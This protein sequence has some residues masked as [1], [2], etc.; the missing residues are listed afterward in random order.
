MDNLTFAVQ[1]F[2]SIIVLI[3][4]EYYSKEEKGEDKSSVDAEVVEYLSLSESAEE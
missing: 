2:C 1:N 4:C 3:V